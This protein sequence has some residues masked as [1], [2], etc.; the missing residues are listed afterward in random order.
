MHTHA[1]VC[2]D[3]QKQD[4]CWYCSILLSSLN[5]E[6]LR[7]VFIDRVLV[8]HGDGIFSA[9]RVRFVCADRV[10]DA[11]ECNLCMF[12]VFGTTNGQNAAI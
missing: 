7:N 2:D 12:S 5:G 3:Y 11:N 6:C 1:F 4:K 10:R 9:F 8:L